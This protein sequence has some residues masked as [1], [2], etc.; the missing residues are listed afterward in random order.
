MATAT[1]DGSMTMPDNRVTVDATDLLWTYEYANAAPEYDTAGYVS[2]KTGKTYITSQVIDEDET[3]NPADLETSDE[4]LAL[5][6]KRELGLGR[7]L[8]FDFTSEFMEEE[9]ETV[10]NYFS[11]SGA[12]RRFKDLLIDKGKLDDWHAFEEQRTRQA[13]SEWCA[14][15]GLEL[16]GGTPDPAGS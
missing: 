13:L 1:I 5:P 14:A 6:D 8:V 4:Y 2:L 16:S 7:D 10:R 12:Y 11:R 3:D 9:W 15:Q